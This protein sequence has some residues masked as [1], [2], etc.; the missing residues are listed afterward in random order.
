MDAYIDRRRI[1]RSIC[2][3]QPTLLHRHIAVSQCAIDAGATAE[4]DRIDGP[5]LIIVATYDFLTTLIRRDFLFY[6]AVSG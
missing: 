1:R 2:F 5:H 4:E 6:R 3:Q